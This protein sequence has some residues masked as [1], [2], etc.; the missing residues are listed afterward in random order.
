MEPV[1]CPNGHPNRPGTRICIVCRALLDPSSPAEPPAKP[2]GDRP[3]APPRKTTIDRLAPPPATAETDESAGPLV[4]PSTAARRRAWPW[5]LLLLLLGVLGVIFLRSLLFPVTRTTGEA[6]TPALDTVIAAGDAVNEQ[7]ASSVPSPTAMDTPS[8]ASAT[9]PIHTPTELSTS[10]PTLVATITPLAT[11]IPPATI[12]GVVITPTFAFGPDANFIQNGDFAN[13]WVNGWSRDANGD[14]V[15]ELIEVQPDSETGQNEL[16]LEKSG[17]G[18]LQLAQRV[19]L[20]FPVEAL[21]FRARVRLAGVATGM[22]EG[23]AAL[24]VR[25]EDSRGTPLGASVWVDGATDETDLWGTEPLPPDGNGASL[26]AHYLGDGWQAI[27]LGLGQELADELPTVDPVA[28][29]QVTVILALLGEESCA[30]VDCATSLA[31]SNIS[32]TAESP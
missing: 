2:A 12:V 4:R 31:V 23:R 19:V 25:Y 5:L 21:V 14:P 29:R 9:A 11:L 24:I 3:T 6:P 8:P 28:I 26:A 22:D 10:A 7:E 20:T 18:S 15:G 32:L 27:E 13:D 17:P 1:Y 30:P 16:R